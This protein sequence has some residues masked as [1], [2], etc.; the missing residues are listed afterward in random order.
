[1][2]IFNRIVLILL[3]LA[4]MVAAGAVFLVSAGAL[5]PET[6]A[7]TAWFADRLRPF[8]QFADRERSQ[9]LLVSAGL[10][11]LGLA[12]LLL[13]IC[14]AGRIRREDV[15]EPAGR[16]TPVVDRAV[17]EPAR[18]DAFADFTRGRR[19]MTATSHG[20]RLPPTMT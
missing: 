11:A 16:A 5:A 10:V 14:H 7:P 13:E 12:L 3:A 19:R 15:R 4:T 9:A 1:M 18:T 2:N 8:A 6:I 20:A 17:Y